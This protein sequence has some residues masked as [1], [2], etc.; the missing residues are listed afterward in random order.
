MSAYLPV[1]LCL[2]AACLLPVSGSLLADDVLPS[3]VIAPAG[4]PSQVSSNDNL[5]LVVPALPAADQSSASAEGSTAE[6]AAEAPPQPA[7]ASESASRRARE[8]WQKQFT[9]VGEKAAAE[10]AKP[11]KRRKAKAGAV[12]QSA[13]T[14][15]EKTPPANV[16]PEIIPQPV[17]LPRYVDVYRT[18]PF[19][20]AEYDVDPS[21]RHNATIELLLNQLRP[22]SPHIDS[23]VNVT[24]RAIEP[25]RNSYPLRNG[26]RNWSRYPWH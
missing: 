11:A 5:P 1:S 17:R 25:Y 12:N 21:Y 20:R 14:G 4:A 16:L 23:N 15:R 2:V 7:S 19:S 8:E 10:P 9:A 13:R 3:V 6:P 24:V 26:Y 18:I 22:A